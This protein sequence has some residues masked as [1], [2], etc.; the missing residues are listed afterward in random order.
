LSLNFEKGIVNEQ[1]PSD[2]ENRRDPQNNRVLLVTVMTDGQLSMP[3]GME[4]GAASVTGQWEGTWQ[5]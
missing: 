5:P 4:I 3:L 1:S 2:I